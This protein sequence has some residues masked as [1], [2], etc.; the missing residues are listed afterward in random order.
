MLVMFDVTCPSAPKPVLKP[1]VA[2]QEIYRP[3]HFLRS[4]R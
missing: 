2:L 3:S 1:K 4:A